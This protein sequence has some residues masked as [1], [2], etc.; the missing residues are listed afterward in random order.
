MLCILTI[1]IVGCNRIEIAEKSNEITL[2]F[3]TQA[4]SFLEPEDILLSSLK[5]STL[6]D[7]ISYDCGCIDNREIF[8]L[9]HRTI[10]LLNQTYDNKVLIDIK[11]CS[12]ALSKL[13]QPSDCYDISCKQ[14]KGYLNI[15][16]N[17][18][19][20]SCEEWGC[21]LYSPTIGITEKDISAGI[22]KTPE[23]IVIDDNHDGNGDGICQYGETCC[24]ITDKL[25]CIGHNAEKILN[26]LTIKGIK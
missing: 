8:V 20:F 17:Q 26:R 23:G 16:Y 14:G 1:F 18:S 19:Y 4:I 25:S 5:V 12:D 3:D 22:S 7:N 15:V 13:Y 24:L 6:K 9:N 11:D 21:K 2:D 10:N